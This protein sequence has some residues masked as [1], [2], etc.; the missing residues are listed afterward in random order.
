MSLWVSSKM[1]NPIF[2]GIYCS[3]LLFISWVLNH[4]YLFTYL[5]L[6]TLL[7]AQV[8]LYK[9]KNFI[10]RLTMLINLFVNPIYNTM[11]LLNDG[12]ML[13]LLNKR[14]FQYVDS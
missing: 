1:A 5:D 4:V 9:G 7:H 10:L 12:I 8:A 13:C 3:G 6:V 11:P 14:Y 2:N